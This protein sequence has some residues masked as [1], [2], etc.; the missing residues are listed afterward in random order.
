MNFAKKYSIF[1]TFIVGIFIGISIIVI[2]K[3]FFSSSLLYSQTPSTNTIQNIEDDNY[4]KYYKMFT[5]AY[6]IIKREFF[7]SKK[8]TAKNL[9][10]GAIKGML[11]SLEDP[12]SIYMEPEFAKEFTTE[13][14]GN[15]SGVGLQVDIRDNWP[16]VISP[17]EDTPAWKAGIKPGDKIIEVEGTST[18]NTPISENRYNK[19]KKQKNRIS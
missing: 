1:I 8:T 5:D 6:K 14:S 17:L 19:H 7:D 11:E 12:Y 9:L 3:T 4:F 16:T 10:S 2:N 18:K 15:F 13:M